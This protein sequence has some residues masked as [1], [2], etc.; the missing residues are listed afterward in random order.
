MKIIAY[1]LFSL[2]NVSLA[3]SQS[4]AQDNS[5]RAQLVKTIRNPVVNCPFR[6]RQ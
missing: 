2:L 4:S 3:W 1:L 5:L 6:F